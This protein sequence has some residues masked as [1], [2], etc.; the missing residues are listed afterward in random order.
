MT[1]IGQCPVCRRW[2]RLTD[3]RRLIRTHVTKGERC[4]GMGAPPLAIGPKPT[5]TPAARVPAPVSVPFERPAPRPR[6]DEVGSRAGLAVAL[7]FL[8][9]ILLVI[10]S[11]SVGGPDDGSETA[12]AESSVSETRGSRH[13]PQRARNHTTRPRQQESSQA[14]PT[15]P[16]DQSAS[17]VEQTFLATIH[18]VGLSAYGPDSEQI[19]LARVMCT[20]LDGG[21]TFADAMAVLGS[22]GYSSS[23]AA[24]YYGIATA[25][26]CPQ[27]MQ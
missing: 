27:H 4:V 2:V 21:A 12:S 24:A 22:A 1:E 26:F 9:V 16:V 6:S 25:S 14:A 3:S 10:I 19:E 18:E 20:T 17:V 15:A 13:S 5:P 7:T 8:V 23:A 11:V